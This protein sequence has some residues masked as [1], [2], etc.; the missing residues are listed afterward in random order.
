MLKNDVTARTGWHA[1]AL[2]SDAA[3][4]YLEVARDGGTDHSLDYEHVGRIPTLI[5]PLGADTR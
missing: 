4:D 5:L 2:F 1:Y 3:A